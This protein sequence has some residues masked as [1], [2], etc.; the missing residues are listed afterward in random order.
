M[1]LTPDFSVEYAI[2]IQRTSH[3][4]NACTYN[5]TAVN[6]GTVCLNK[7]TFYI[8]SS[9]PF[10]YYGSM[11][12]IGNYSINLLSCLKTS[13]ILLSFLLSEISEPEN[14]SSTFIP[15][16]WST[17]IGSTTIQSIINEE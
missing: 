12:G 10:C 4:G 13:R 11:L 9:L 3:T 6:G 5:I 1:A 7:V 2:L 15:L 8:D 17:K 14:P 16:Y